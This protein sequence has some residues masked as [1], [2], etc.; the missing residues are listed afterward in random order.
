MQS[1]QYRCIQPK[2]FADFFYRSGS[3]YFRIWIVNLVLTIVTLGL[4]YPW[5]KVRRLRYFYNNTHI[6]NYAFDFHGDPRKMLRG[7]LL[8]WSMGVLYAIAGNVS[9]VAQTVMFAIFVAVWP[10]LF[11]S[12]MQFRL[13]NTSWRG[14]RFQFKGN[15]AGAYKVLLPMLLPA[16]LIM[17]L[18]LWAQGGEQQAGAPS[19]VMQGGIA[20][21]V[22]AVMLGSLFMAPWWF[23]DLKKYQHDHYALGAVQTELNATVRSFYGAFFKISGVTLMGA[24]APVV[25]IWIVYLVHGA[26]EPKIGFLAF[27][28]WFGSIILLPRPYIDSRLQN[29]LWNHTGCGK[30]LQ[31]RSELRFRTLL[32][33]MAK[34]SFLVMVTFG[35]Y[36]PFA[37]VALA[38]TQLKAVAVATTVNLDQLDD[39]LRPKS[40]T[41]V[42]DA[43]GE[44]L[45]LDVGL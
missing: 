44:F 32:G 38:R 29:L 30:Q 9:H 19:A 16:L 36:W 21:A 31:F 43:T 3:E 2:T 45:G 14:L 20:F 5:A 28:L 6:D 7:F 33:L 39:P 37:K 22:S 24:V 8:V 4:Y 41:A 15:V 1:V 13:A 40:A 12:S 11:Q 18:G 35:L 26:I 27:V 25:F 10:A 34:N 17:L 23:R 42:G